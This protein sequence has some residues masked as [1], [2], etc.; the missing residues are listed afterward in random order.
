MNSWGHGARAFALLAAVNRHGWLRFL[1]EP[2]E[3]AEVAEFAG[4]SV[5]RTGD[6]LEALVANG[7]AGRDGDRYR[8]AASFAEL[9]DDGAAFD[10][11]AQIEADALRVRQIAD[12]VGTGSAPATEQDA[13]VIARSF[14]LRP[15]E[16]ARGLIP[17]LLEPMPEVLPAMR[18]GRYLDVGSGVGGF[19]LN[20]AVVHPGVRIT[21]V[22]RIP[23]V[24]AELSRRA[25]EAGVEDRVEVR[26]ADA[27]TLDEADAYDAAFWAHAF[28][29]APT[30]AE[31]LAA[32]RRAL[33]PGGWLILQE[34]V[35][36]SSSEAARAD[37]ALNR[38]V[39]HA[40]EL[41]FSRP[42]EE[43]AKEAE[44]GGFEFVRVVQ[45]PFGRVALLRKP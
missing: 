24:A 13:L 30:R 8:L 39:A 16:S 14:G 35:A 7:V 31:S 34:M 23:A 15:V 11:E 18:E 10:V 1:A 17:A 37:F 6:I 12:I 40:Q 21:A 44:A 2:R 3:Q 41:P 45:L 33:R 43:L 26:L 36:D 32:V 9:L 22:E 38:L 4:L 42:A 29:P 25:K 20:A 5:E 19:L 28:F 27:R